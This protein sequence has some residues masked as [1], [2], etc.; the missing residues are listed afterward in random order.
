MAKKG[1]KAMIQSRYVRGW[2]RNQRI[3][4]K[5][6]LVFV[7]LIA[8]SLFVLGYVSNRMMTS[9]VIDKTFQNVASESQLIV[10]RLRESILNAE[11][12]A[13]IM[14]VNLN[15]VVTANR[16]S[17]QNEFTN[18]NLTKQVENQLD[19]DLLF[20]PDIEAAAF[21]DTHNHIYTTDNLMSDGLQKAFRSKILEQIDQSAGQNIW[22]TMEARDFLTMHRD[23]PV[24]TLGKKI[25]EINS[26]EQLGTLILIIKES[27]FSAI[28]QNKG[29][30]EGRNYRVIDARGLVVSSMDKNELLKPLALS[31]AT[32]IWNSGQPST[33][34]LKW[35]GK[36]YLISSAPI[37]IMGWKLVSQIPVVALTE[38]TR[39][40]TWLIVGMGIFGIVFSFLVAEMFSRIIATPLIRLTKTMLKVR[41]GDL[42]ISFDVNA[43]D[44]I[45]YLASGFNKMLG[46]IR[47]L[48]HQVNAEQKQKRHYELAL[49]QAQIKPHF[50]YNTLDLVYVLCSMQRVNEAR[51]A[52]KALADFYR[53]AL[54]GGKEVISVGDEIDNVGNY[55]AIQGIRYRDVFEYAF[56]VDEDIL[57]HRILKLT[58]QPLVENAIYHGL[59]PSGSGGKL[60]IQGSRS[61][62]EIRITV[63]DNG[64]GMEPEQV[65]RLLEPRGKD[66]DAKKSFGLLNVHE[67]IKL[68]F[69]YEYGLTVCSQKGIGTMVTIKLPSDTKGECDDV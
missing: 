23:A 8:V 19:L 21:L 18:Q 61:R 25:I 13:N 12:C 20:F 67:R 45:G 28:F 36:R 26:G 4:R 56:E 22:F 24:L 14:T 32:D 59:K 35:A 42:H 60:L 39:K 49:I 27:S 6:V 10:N 5:I 7:P 62:D 47:E 33:A 29:Q 40:V 65:K 66:D 46:Q 1:G 53:I 17:E 48:I 58:I 55:L 44:E 63:S 41:E 31:A 69:G 2:F 51:D 30:V 52:T 34:I 11:N 54:S 38:D 43:S 37:D 16:E 50:L 9:S 3:K 68:F 57:E 15:K 64:V